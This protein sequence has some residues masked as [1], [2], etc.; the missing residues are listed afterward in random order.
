MFLHALPTG[1]GL[2]AVTGDSRLLFYGSGEDDDSDDSAEGNITV[3]RELIGSTDEM[4]SAERLEEM[5]DE[6]TFGLTLDDVNDPNYRKSHP[7]VRICTQHCSKQVVI[8]KVLAE[9]VQEVLLE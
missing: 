4:P 9:D 1:D 6:A 8:P 3:Q 7:L 2:L 5:K